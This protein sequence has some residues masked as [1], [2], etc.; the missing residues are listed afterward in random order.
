MTITTHPDPLI[1][2][3]ARASFVDGPGVRTTVFFKGCPLCC[4]WCHNPESQDYKVQTFFSPEDCIQC[5]NCENGKD[6]F[7]LARQDIGKRY[8]A[9]QLAE[10]I[11][12]D[13]PYYETSGGGVTFSGGEALSFIGYLSRVMPILKAQ[14]I[15][16]AVQT[17]GYFD[18]DQFALTLLPHIDVIYFD[19]KIMDNEA[20]TRLLGKSNQLILENFVQLLLHDILVVPRIPLI[21]NFVATPE[22]LDALAGFFLKHNVRQCEFLYYHPGLKEK[23]FRL[24]RKPDENLPEKS[25]SM[26]ENRAWIDYFK[27]KIRGREA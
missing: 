16:I 1:F 23:L 14:N 19:F 12:Q 13:K 8:P 26:A 2:D 18:F 9:K 6:C 22:N 3:I 25:V 21:P 24:N 7:T 17:C 5:G 15:H 4:P 11:L 27:Q 20:H 10:L